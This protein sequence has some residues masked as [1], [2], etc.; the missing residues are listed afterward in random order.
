MCQRRGS[1]AASHAKRFWMKKLTAF[2]QNGVFY[3]FSMVFYGFSMVFLWVFD[4]FS[5]VFPW[6]SITQPCFLWFFEGFLFP[7]NGQSCLRPTAA[8]RFPWFWPL[9]GSRRL[10]LRNR[11][12]RS[13][14][15]FRLKKKTTSE[16]GPLGFVFLGFWCLFGL[17]GLGF[18]FGLCFIGFSFVSF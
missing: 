7:K 11:H 10:H 3:R 2:A 18:G 8:P 6:F 12:H 4:G 16:A 15:V 1:K 9:A 14:G 13:L 17:W 5:M